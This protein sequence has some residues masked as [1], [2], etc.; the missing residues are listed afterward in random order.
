MASSD[1]EQETPEETPA[2]N[3]VPIITRSGVRRAQEAV[4]AEPPADEMSEP[5]MRAVGFRRCRHGTAIAAAGAGMPQYLALACRHGTAI[6]HAVPAR[7]GICRP[8]FAPRGGD[9]IVLA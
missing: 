4:D 2:T 3:I 1:G 9:A 6:C 8:A 5:R 7:H